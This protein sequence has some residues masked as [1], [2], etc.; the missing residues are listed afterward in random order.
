MKTVAIISEY[1]PFHTGHEYQISRIRREFG[2]DTRIIAIMSGNYTQRAE[3]AIMDK[4]LRAECAVRCGVDLVLELPFPY[5]S[6]SAELF[7]RGGVYIADSLGVV[8]VLSFGSESGDVEALKDVAEVTS[9]D[10]FE[11]RLSEL[12]SVPV[13]CS[14]GYPK[15]CEMAYYELSTKAK[16]CDVTTSNNILAIEY[17]KALSNLNSSIL[18]HTLKRDGADYSEKSIIASP[19]QSASAIRSLSILDPHSALKYIAENARQT[20]LSAIKDGAFPC[21]N[22]RLSTAII[23]YIRLSDPAKME[24]IHDAGDG[25]YNRI[26]N[27]S[28]N[29]DSLTE[30]IKLSDTKK[31]TTARIRRAILNSYLGVTS[32]MVKE[33]PLYTQVLAMNSVGKKILKEIKKK[34]SVPIITKSASFG[35]L[36]PEAKRQKEFSDRADFVFQLT[37][38]AFIMGAIALKTTPFIAD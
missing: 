16:K 15:L 20:I 32:S 38:P 2:S 12:S 28:F 35:H 1:N 29:T 33:L 7:A 10:E 23:S 19:H 5:S 18:P 34:G 36:S 17:I 30:L 26:Y 4:F 11:K 31:Y 13:N 14:I 24:S 25:I 3:T 37:R 9:S 21:D 22:E 27:Q 6:S 8:D